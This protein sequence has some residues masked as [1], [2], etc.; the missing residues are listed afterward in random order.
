MATANKRRFTDAMLERLRP[1]REGRLELGDE[2]VPGLLL[3]VTPGGR[4]SFSVIYKVPGAGGVNPRTGRLLAGRQ[5]RVTLGQY[6]IVGLA[7]ARE[8]ARG[9]LQSVTEGRDPRDERREANLLLVTNTVEAVA[10]R[11]IEQ[12]AKRTIK[13]WYKIEQTFRDH[14]NPKIGHVPLAEVRRADVHALLDE[15]VAEGKIG[16]AREVR[17]HISRLF[18]WAMD[19]EIVADNPVNGLQRNDLRQQESGRA[20]TDIEIRC[21]WQAGVELGYPF[22]DW[23]RLLLLTGRRRNEWAGARRS[24]IDAVNRIHELPKGRHKSARGHALPLSDPA[25]AIIDAMPVWPGNDYFLLST[26]G[27][28]KHAQDHSGAKRTLDARVLEL[29]REDDPE[30]ELPH[31]TFHDLRRTCETRLAALGF[32]PDV[33]GAVLGHAKQGL[34]RVYNKHDYMDE[35]RAALD[36]YGAHILEIVE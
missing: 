31:Y 18:N 29:L 35:M 21:I 9:L 6:P 3:R 32:G 14:I 33:F 8:Q 24:E 25:W 10:Q 27:G 17:K 11:F 16:V 28:E 12:D 19:R 13:S 15:K 20:L 30:A 5:Q 26:T 1:P 36:A 23:V 2:I 7:D 34:Q 4:K 22:G